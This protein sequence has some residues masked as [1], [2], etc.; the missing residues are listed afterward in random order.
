MPR[1]RKVHVVE[2]TLRP[3]DEPDEPFKWWLTLACGHSAG[4]GAKP[5]KTKSR[6][7]RAVTLYPEKMPCFLCRTK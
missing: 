2:A 5:I 6:D 7:Q 4:V 1:T 3:S